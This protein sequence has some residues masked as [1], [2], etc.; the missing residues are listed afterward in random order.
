[1]KVTIYTIKDCEFSKQE[2]DYLTSKQ[3]AFDEKD[4]ESNREWL[5]EMLAVSNNFAGT[6]VTKIEKDDGQ[7]SV[8][9]GFT[10]S[11][12]DAILSPTTATSEVKA[13]DAV[14]APQDSQT[15]PTPPKPDEPPTPT[16]TPPTPPPI[17][18]P[19]PPIVDTP[20]QPPIEVTPPQPTQPLP[21]LDLHDPLNS[22]MTDLQQKSQNTPMSASSTPPATEPTGVS[23]A[24]A[25]ASVPDFPQS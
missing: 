22:I 5:T 14:H 16:P 15:P 19:K 18:E 1:M 6:P 12:F 11:E 25:T 10:Q 3:I 21:P 2:K 13:D 4:I 9:K 23:S 20:P 8:L 17:P 24:P 7:I